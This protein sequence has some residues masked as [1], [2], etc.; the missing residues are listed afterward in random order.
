MEQLDGN[1]LIRPLSAYDG[2]PQRKVK[3]ISERG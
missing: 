3:P 1:K 2:V